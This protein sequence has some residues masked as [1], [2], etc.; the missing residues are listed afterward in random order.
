MSIL[1]LAPLSFPFD[2]SDHHGCWLLLV[3][4]LELCGRELSGGVFTGFGS[5][6]KPYPK[7]WGN[8]GPVR[9]APGVGIVVPQGMD[10]HAIWMQH[11][12]N[13]I[14]CSIYIYLQLS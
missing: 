8:A 5:C 4:T 14:F 6:D 2:A 7:G 11:M 1:L 3:L 13:F 12:E 9:C 10:A